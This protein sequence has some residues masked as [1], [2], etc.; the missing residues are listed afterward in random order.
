MKIYIAGPFFNKEELQFV[1]EIELQLKSN[2]INFFSPRKEGILK[3]MSEEDRLKK[4][5][6]IFNKNISEM[7]ECTH[8]IAN[9]DNFDTGTMFEIGFF[10]ALGKPVFTI[11][12]HNYGLNIMIRNASICHNISVEQVVKN[13][14][15]YT[16]SGYIENSELSR[17]VT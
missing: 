14:Q 9:I 4:M 8:M 11:S 17:E 3:D 2:N 1:K 13:I 7:K 10:H 15:T 5:N 16:Y 6:D 12:N